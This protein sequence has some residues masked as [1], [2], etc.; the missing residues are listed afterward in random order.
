MIGMVSQDL[1]YRGGACRLVIG[2]GNRF[3]ENCTVHI[4]TEDGGGETRIGDDNL[5]MVAAHGA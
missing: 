2:N 4:G 1:K 3:R 5:I